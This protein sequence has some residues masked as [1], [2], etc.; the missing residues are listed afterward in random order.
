MEVFFA[1]WLLCG[2]GAAVVASSKGR[3][4]CGWLIVGCH[5]LPRRRISSSMS[6]ALH[7]VTRG[8]SFTGSGALPS[9]THD[10]Q[11]EAETGIKGAMPRLR[12]PTICGRRRNALLFM[13][14]CS[15][16]ND[17]ADD[18]QWHSTTQR[19]KF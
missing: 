2:I 13:F 12:D 14:A 8:D 18:M 19:K 7:T 17:G 10:H 3:S 6:E 1:I 9:R 16:Y 4:G 11:V 5:R 15:S